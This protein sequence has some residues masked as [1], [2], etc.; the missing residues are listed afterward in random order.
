MQFC[1]NHKR[2]QQKILSL[3]TPPCPCQSWATHRSQHLNAFSKVPDEGHDGHLLHEPLNFTE[4]HH[5]P[6]FIRQVFQGLP[7]PLIEP[8]HFYLI[9]S[10][11]EPHQTF[12]KVYRQGLQ[13]KSEDRS[14]HV[15]V[16]KRTSSPS[17]PA[18]GWADVCS[19]LMS[20]DV[21]MHAGAGS[22]LCIEDL[23][24]SFLE[25]WTTTATISFQGT[26][27]SKP[28]GTTNKWQEEKGEGRL[29][30]WWLNGSRTFF[31]HVK[32]C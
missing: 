2:K 14:G 10:W 18:H 22:W 3:C 21:N 12:Y 1:K 13:V 31:R 11:Q 15:S 19:R 7:F 16:R 8:K 20:T 23:H 30:V 9:L 27:S 25:T 32:Y 5:E 17:G 6:V 28:L 4:L 29:N 26:S 24:W